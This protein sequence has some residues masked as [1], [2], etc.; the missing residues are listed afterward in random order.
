MRIPED[1]VHILVSL[2]SKVIRISMSIPED[3]IHILVSLCRR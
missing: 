2:V 3:V 1:V